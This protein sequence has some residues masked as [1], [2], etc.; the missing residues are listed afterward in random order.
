[1][2]LAQEEHDVRALIL[3]FFV[4]NLW[5]FSAGAQRAAPNF[6]ALNSQDQAQ[7]L[8]AQVEQTMEMP[9]TDTQDSDKQDS[10]KQDDKQDMEM[11]GMDMSQP[12]PDWMP[13][14]HNSSGTGWQPASMPGHMWMRA[15][16]ARAKQSL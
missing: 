13:S 5:V 4:I 9:G 14:P 3:G 11:P 7:L 2:T 8:Q 15:R 10:D 1:L 16:E 6:S 12:A